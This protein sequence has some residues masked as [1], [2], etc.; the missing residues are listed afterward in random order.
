MERRNGC[1]KSGMKKVPLDA[2]GVL[3]GPTGV[4]EPKERG[5]LESGWGLVLDVLQQQPPF[6]CS[7]NAQQ[8]QIAIKLLECFL[9]LI[10]S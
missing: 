2:G 6:G 3:E 1:K 10:L 7:S 8:A 5:R 9:S 4:E